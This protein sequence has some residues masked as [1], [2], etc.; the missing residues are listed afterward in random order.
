MNRR[1]VLTW[2][3]MI[4]ALVLLSVWDLMSGPADVGLRDVFRALFRPSG[5]SA[6]TVVMQIRLPRLLTAVLAGAALA[7]SG[8]QMQ[9]VF[10]NPLADPHIL[11]V[12]A[13]AGTGAAAVMLAGGT[14]MFSGTVAS[15]LGMAA[16]AALGAV[17]VSAVIMAVSS[18]VDSRSALLVMGV[19]IGFVMSAVTSII[20][21]QV[22]DTRLRMFWNWSAGSFGGNGWMETAVMAACLAAGSVISI[23]GNKGLSILLFGDEYARAAGADVKRIR[24]TAMLSCCLMTGA[25]TAF[26]GP[27]GFVGIVAPHV[28]RMVSGES[29]MNVVLPLSLVAGSVM[30][31][32]GDILSRLFPTPVPV[33][34][35]VA[36]L[37]IPLVFLIMYTSRRNSL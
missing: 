21:Y 31:L 30:G 18:R 29:G 28:V 23:S 32:A 15:G 25:V 24:F 5:G 13:G 1:L 35:A 4:S 19:M 11:G 36:I 22:D 27:I 7:L 14:A 26:C 17:A 12:S 8:A 33:G 16:G 3:V 9:A 2:G 10:R 20:Q 37:G 34:S 6:D